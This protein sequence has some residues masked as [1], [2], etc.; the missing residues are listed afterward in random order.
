MERRL[1]EEK[2]PREEKK[3]SF[4]KASS[5]RRISHLDSHRSQNGEKE[6]FHKLC[7]FSFVNLTLRK[8]SSSYVW[9]IS[10]LLFFFRN[11]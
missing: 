5:K 7:Q 2:R 8:F 6:Y 4:V 3:E 11:A 1:Q 10:A 9:L